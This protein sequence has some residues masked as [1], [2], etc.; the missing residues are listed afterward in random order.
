MKK[1]SNFV[2]LDD[3]FPN[4][5]TGFRVAEYNYYLDHFPDLKIYST[6]SK[7]D[8]FYNEYI[9]IY[10]EYKGRILKFD[11]ALLDSC[12][13]VYLNFLNNAFYFL[14]VL[15]KKLI[16]FLMTLYPGGGF[17]IK[18]AE[19]DAKLKTVLKSP[20]L[21]GVIATQ[22]ITSDYLRFMRCK[23]PVHDLYG[24]CMNPIYF[25][26]SHQKYKKNSSIFLCFVADKYM[27]QGLNKGYPEFIKTAEKLVSR[28]KNLQF[29]VVG[30][31]DYNDYPISHDLKKAIT[32]KGFLYTNALK[33]FF[34]TQDIIISPNKPFLLSQGNFDGFP[35]GCCVEA[36]LS[37]VAVVCSDE[38][39]LNQYY[40]NYQDMIICKPEPDILFEEVCNLIEDRKLLEKI[41]RS[42]QAISKRIFSPENQ[43]ASRAMHIHSY[44]A[45]YSRP[46]LTRYVLNFFKLLINKI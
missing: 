7:F 31:F 13:F 1:K 16:P 3:C 28:F 21:C 26:D 36:S 43:L 46:S 14:P 17:A 41:K 12:S 2:V 8:R 18:E 35:T 40:K 19:S 24:G 45:E 10:P 4:L 33:E 38:L 29:F 32:F 23:V 25:N 5:A 6:I 9:N 22:N 37:G 11:E 42:G 39:N 20:L 27:P 34:L 30:G 44:F 15:E